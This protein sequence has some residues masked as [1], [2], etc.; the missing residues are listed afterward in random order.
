M[1]SCAGGECGASANDPFPTLEERM[2]KPLTL[3]LKNAGQLMRRH[4]VRGCLAVYPVCHE[5]RL[6]MHKACQGAS[7]FACCDA[8]AA[9]FDSTCKPALRPHRQALPA[10]PEDACQGADHQ[11]H[12]AVVRESAPPAFLNVHHC[13]RA[14][15]NRCL[16]R[17]CYILWLPAHHSIGLDDLTVRRMGPQVQLRPGARA[18]PAAVH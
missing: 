7:C 10:A 5:T 18:L 6:R 2:S 9:P 3:L 8:T 17:L 15:P 1:C 16:G 13:I 14:G 4:C 11:R 12:R